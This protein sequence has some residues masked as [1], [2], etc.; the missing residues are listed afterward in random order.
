M[1][2]SIAGCITVQPDLPS[3][4][5]LQCLCQLGCSVGRVQQQQIVHVAFL[6]HTAAVQA[7]LALALLFWLVPLNAN[8]GA[9]MTVMLKIDWRLA[10][11]C[12]R[13]EYAW[14]SS[15]HT[16]TELSQLCIRSACSKSASGDLLGL[17]DLSCEKFCKLKLCKPL[18]HQMLQPWLT[19]T[20]VGVSIPVSK[21]ADLLD[22]S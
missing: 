5:T 4:A 13:C 2:V 6:T 10:C 22:S 18:N 20:S 19:T 15:R 12:G 1:K 8:D 11:T 3:V 14:C 7:A 17:V 9:G 16:S 21:T